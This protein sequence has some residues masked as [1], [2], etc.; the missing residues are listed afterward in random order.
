MDRRCSSKASIHGA[1]TRER[2]FGYR[3]T[4]RAPKTNRWRRYRSPCLVM[5]PSLCL[6][7][8]EFCRGVRSSQTAN[9]RPDRK[10]D[11]SGMVAADAVAV[12][13][14][15]P[16]M[17]AS[18]RQIELVLWISASRMSI[19][20]ICWFSASNCP[21]RA[22]KAKHALLSYLVQLRDERM[23]PVPSL[24]DDNSILGQMRSKRTSCHSSLSD[25]KPSSSVQHQKSLILARFDWDK[26][27]VGT[28][29]RFTNGGRISGVVLLAP[30]HEGFDVTWRNETKVMAAPLQLSS[31]VVGSRT[32]LDAD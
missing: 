32:H 13:G 25:Q 7:P 29:H 26:A 27:H 1:S 20:S 4:V 5:P 16:G 31:P 14:P 10:S 12:I 2:A 6:P 15:I 8:D 22:Y 9:S 11:G 24:W 19:R 21:T 17:V 18:K 3:T 28:G 23:D 30:S